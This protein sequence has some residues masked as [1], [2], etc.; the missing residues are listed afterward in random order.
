MTRRNFIKWLI[1][2]VWA[3]ILTISGLITS[4]RFRGAEGDN[5]AMPSTAAPPGSVTD[6]KQPTEDAGP[7]LSFFIIS[8]LHINS[9]ITAQSNHLRKALD[10]IKTF[11][12]K[13]QAIVI[14][15]DITDSG[16][17]ADYREFKN[18]MSRYEL[19]PVYA[20]MGNH[21]Y[22]NVWIGKDGAWNHDSFPNGKTDSMARQAFTSMFNLEKPYHDVWLNGFHFILLSQEAYIQERPEVGEGAWYSDEQMSWFRSKMAENNDGKP[23]FVMIH[24]E[25]PPIGQDGGNHMLIKAKEFREILKPYRNVFVFS[26]HTHQDFTVNTEHYIQETFHWFRN[27]SIG[28]VMNTK[29]ENVRKDA[30]QGLYIEVYPDKVVLRG[31]EFSDR[32]WIKEADWSVLISES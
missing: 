28:L 22:Y 5:R 16:T 8:D 11:G 30:A 3:S 14:T 19:P 24:Q 25:L 15:G 7:L 2:A 29:Y 4:R 1:A 17:T 6:E 10:D 18:I 32:T 31:R 20:N 13:V 27:S 26:G 9:G 23:V 21:D 12:D